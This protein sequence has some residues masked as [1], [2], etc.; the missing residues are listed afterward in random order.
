MPSPIRIFHLYRYLREPP[1]EQKSAVDCKPAMRWGQTLIKMPATAMPDRPDSGMLWALRSGI[2]EMLY[3][4]M[5]I[6]FLFLLTLVLAGC[7]QKG[8]LYLPAPDA[9]WM[10]CRPTLP[11][12][13]PVIGPSPSCSKIIHAFGHQHLGLTLA[14]VTGRIVADLLDGRQPNLAIGGLSAA[15]SFL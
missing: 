14:G 8:D 2:D 3:R 6:L 13:L 1:F 11:D 15:R 7:G 10:G 5:R 12:A 4:S 9:T